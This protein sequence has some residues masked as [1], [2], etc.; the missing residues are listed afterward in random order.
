[1]HTAAMNDVMASQEAI[2]DREGL[3]RLVEVAG[4]TT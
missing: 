3:L 4:R 2:I 1:M